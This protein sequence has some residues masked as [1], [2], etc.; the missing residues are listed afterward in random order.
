VGSHRKL[1]KRFCILTGTFV[2]IGALAS[3]CSSPAAVPGTSGTSPA[4]TGSPTQL[5]NDGVAALS[6][7]KSST[8]TADFNAVISTDPSDKYLNNNIAYYDLGVINQTQGNTNAA[9]TD[10]KDAIVLD[11]NYPA[12]E[13]N[14]AIEETA[15][16]PTGAIAL[17]R[18]VISASPSDVNAIYNLGLLLYETGQKTEGE[19]Y[20]SQAIKMAPSLAKK[21]PAGVTP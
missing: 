11:A 17:Y 9:I 7:G 16:D 4:V 20:L 19:T 8:A 3:A 18:Q 13:Y 14:L 15:S 21:V 5:L 6:A 12:A 10:Y 2:T 1:T